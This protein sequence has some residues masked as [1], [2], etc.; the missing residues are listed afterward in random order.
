MELLLIRLFQTIKRLRII[1]LLTFLCCCSLFANAQYF[2]L[3]G[4]RKH[5]NIPFRMVRDMVT[6]I[7]LNIKQQR[8]IQFYF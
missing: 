2:D 4:S 7:R 6:T 5:L 3:E 8:P 1:V